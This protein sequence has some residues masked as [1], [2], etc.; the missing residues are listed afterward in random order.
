MINLAKHVSVRETPQS[1]PIPGKNQQQNNAGG[2]SYVVDCWNRLHRFLILGSEGGTYYVGERKLTQANCTVLNQC[3]AQDGPRTVNM[4]VAISESG[5]APKNDPAIFAL[6]ILSNSDDREVR[7][8]AFEAVPHVCRT[9]THL[10]QFV[11]ACKELRGWGRGMRKAVAGWYNDKPLEKLAYQVTKY[12]NRAGY[13]HRDLLRLSHPTPTGEDRQKLYHWIVKGTVEGE[14][15]ADLRLLQGFQEI[16]DPGMDARRAVKLIQDYKLTLEHVPNTLLGSL[17]VW[18]ALLPNLPPTAMIRNLGKMT[19]V[20]LLKPLS[21]ATKTVCDTLTN[22]ERLKGA[23]VHPLSVLL[24]SDVYESGHGLKGSLTW[25]P[26]Q[27][28]TAALEAAFYAAFDAVEP[29][30]KRHLLALDVSGSMDCSY[31]AGTHLTARKASACMAMVTNRVE[32]QTHMVGFSHQLVPVNISKRTALNDV[33]RTL[34][35]IPMGG[36]DCALPM[37][38]AM[39]NKLDVD[40]FVV[41]TDSETWAG[42]IHPTQALLQYRR[43]TGI[44]AKLIVVGMTATEFTIADP[45]DSGML[46]V[47]GFD[48]SCPAVMSDFVRN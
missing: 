31:L 32:S 14:M 48:S 21:A 28:I 39:Q 33:I 19:N 3:A 1:E 43:A 34:D 7:R 8:L 6:A 26:V 20:G 13:T 4:I 15:P 41:Y 40:A 12:R 46:D 24:A 10:F 2:F 5:R 30:G 38:Y 23:R 9:S 18:D 35:R 47:V 16:N 36:T 42:R 22:A 17:E 45:T 44:N 29:T 37:I 11:A 25:Q 27:Q